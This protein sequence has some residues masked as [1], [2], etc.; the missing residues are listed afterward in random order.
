MASSTAS[1]L[2]PVVHGG[3]PMPAAASRNPPAPRPSSKRPSPTR[4]REAAALAIIAGGRRG[5]F[6]TAGKIRIRE[7]RASRCPIRTQVSRKRRW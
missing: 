2:S 5:R 6:A 4:S 3:A 1:T 7:V